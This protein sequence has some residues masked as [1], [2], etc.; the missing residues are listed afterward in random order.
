MRRM[1]L[2]EM[3]GLELKVGASMNAREGDGDRDS[4]PNR[5]G[6]LRQRRES[7]VV[8][9]QR[10][11]LLRLSSSRLDKPGDYEKNRI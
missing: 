11:C 7:L 10:H 1:G 4:S 6:K 8:E 2:R 5:Q 3:V 9:E